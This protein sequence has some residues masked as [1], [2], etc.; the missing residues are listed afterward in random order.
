MSDRKIFNEAIVA[1]LFARW[2]SELENRDQLAGAIVREC[3]G[4]ATWQA[5][6]FTLSGAMDF[7]D[8]QQEFLTKVFRM[9]PKYNPRSG[10]A[11]AFLLNGVQN[12]GRTILARHKRHHHEGKL[13][14]VDADDLHG[15]D[16]QH[17][18]NQWL[19][20]TK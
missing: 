15:A 11:Y 16:A 13:F 6:K 14:Y 9:I 20:Q 7:N 19:L 12:H 17:S 8:W 2:Q 3:Q 4:L 1:G 18:F 10:S 5:T